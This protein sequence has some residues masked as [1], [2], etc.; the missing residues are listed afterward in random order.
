MKRQAI[1]SHNFL[2]GLTALIF[3][4]HILHD[5][6]VSHLMCAV[7]VCCSRRFSND[8]PCASTAVATMTSASSDIWAKSSRA[9]K[10]ILFV[11]RLPWLHARLWWSAPRLIPKEWRLLQIW[12]G[13]GGGTR[14][15]PSPPRANK[16][17]D[18]KAGRVHEPSA[19]IVSIKLSECV[20]CCCCQRLKQSKGYF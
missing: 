17:K 3:K 9:Q 7:L 14:S 12:E 19:A 15:P 20:R 5:V 8:S 2:K 6:Y 18:N 1:K 11:R 10:S 13:W 16:V 4:N